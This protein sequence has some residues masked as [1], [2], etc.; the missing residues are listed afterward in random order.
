M[1]HLCKVGGSKGLGVHVSV[2]EFPVDLPRLDLA[3]GDLFL[4]IV[5]DHQE[6]FALLGVSLAIVTT[7]L[8]SSM[9]TTAG[10]SRVI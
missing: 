6:V 4:D 7:A 1:S 3:H 2:A 5:E 10:S 9:M 8:L